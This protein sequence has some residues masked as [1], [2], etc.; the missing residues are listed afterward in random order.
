MGPVFLL[1]GGQRTGSTLIQRLILS[2]R[3]V[4]VWGEHGGI[5]IPQLRSLFNQTVSWAEAENGYKHL[6]SFKANAHHV[7]APN[8]NPEPPYFHTG[9]RAFL[10]QSLGAAA[11]DMGYPRWGFKEVRYARDE[12]RT[13][14]A[15]FPR[16]SFIFLVRNPVSCLRSIKV[17]HWYKGN[18]NSDPAKFL[19]EWTRVSGNLADVYPEYKRACFVRYEDAISNPAETVNTIARTIDVPAAAF[20]LSVFDNLLRGTSSSPA[21]LDP[22]DMAALQNSALLEVAGK[23]GYQPLELL[24]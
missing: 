12:V 10:E 24:G 15:L 20:D 9:C 19:S 23:L 16:A 4:L 7:W 17:A 5:L 11:R 21:A 3:Q 2:T 22:A 18:F 1:A 14:Q 6:A 8:M 13:L